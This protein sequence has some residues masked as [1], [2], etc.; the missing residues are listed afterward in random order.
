M[1]VLIGA[2]PMGLEKGIPE[3]QARFPEIEFA[4]CPTREDTINHIG[5]ADVYMGWLNR[6]AFVAAKK[7]KWIQSPSSGV[8]YYLEIP[9]FLDSDVL[10]TS[11]SGT[12]GA[13]VAESAMAMI[14]SFTRGIRP[15]ILRQEEREWAGAE[16]RRTMSELTETTMGIIGLGAIGR[17]LAKRAKAF[18][19]RVIAVDLFPNNKPDYADELWGL[20][21]LNDL[22]AESDYVVIMV[23]YTDE[24][25]NMIGA[26]Q[27][28]HMKPTAMLVAMSRGGILDQ[29]AL[30][31]ALKEKKLAGA[32]LDVF[33]PEPL[34][35]DHELWG[36]EN[37]L[38]TP[39]IAGGTQYEGRY[40]LRI[41]AENLERLLK[42]Q[43]PLQNQVDKTRGF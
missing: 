5:D 21:R 17:A 34:G 4:V 28:N 43:L 30:V 12:H 15:S 7:L 13:C 39:H 22:M 6:E 14:L 42:G 24:T 19:M 33:K 31:T 3:L 20:E 41:F 2:N 38:V 35:P 27:L 40:I 11:A 8:N 29:D 1:K 16:I 23:P 37:V 18:D 25:A 36:M 26:E 10:L 9:E 32:A